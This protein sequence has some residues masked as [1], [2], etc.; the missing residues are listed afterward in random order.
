MAKKYTPSLVRDVREQAKYIARYDSTISAVMTL[1]GSEALT[2]YEA[3]K[4]AVIALNALAQ[5][6]EP[7]LP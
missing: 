3:Y 5:T 2:A 7:L 4:A 1:I 6:I